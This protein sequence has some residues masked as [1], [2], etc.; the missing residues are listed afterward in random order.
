MT[1]LWPCP[2]IFVGVARPLLVLAVLGCI[3]LEGPLAA[4]DPDRTAVVAALVAETDR[5]SAAAGI[6][7]AERLQR[8]RAVLA[9][10]FDVEAM[11]LAALGDH[12]ARLDRTQRRAYLAAY[13]THL[14]RGFLH[15][16]RKYGPAVTVLLGER[17]LPSGEQM[18]LT[19]S[20]AGARRFDTVFFLCLHDPARVCDLEIEGLRASR[21]ERREFGR[22]LDRDGIEALIAELAS[23]RLW[24]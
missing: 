15:H 14:E 10:S 13:R 5:I 20:T 1:R 6:D 12:R 2:A 21:R 18:V 22:I 11:G 23:G 8:F 3:G 9:R 7:D 16:A 4:A 24:P 17:R 19:R